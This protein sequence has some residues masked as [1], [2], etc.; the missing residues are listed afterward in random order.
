MNRDSEIQPK[1]TFHNATTSLPSLL[2]TGYKQLLKKSFIP[3]SLRRISLNPILDIDQQPSNLTQLFRLSKPP[4]V[5]S[6]QP[7]KQ[8]K[9]LS[10]ARLGSAQLGSG[11]SWVTLWFLS[12]P[13]R[14]CT[15]STWWC[16]SAE[17]GRPSR[18]TCSSTTP[19]ACCSS[20]GRKAR[21]HRSRAAASRPASESWVPTATWWW[22]LTTAA[23][24]EMPCEKRRYLLRERQ[25]RVA[26]AL[27]FSVCERKRR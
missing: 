13:N 1:W 19:A 10:L 5:K 18:A 14:C 9:H 20:R 15:T 6:Q 16:A 22:P 2:I 12:P 11:T 17:A 25:T 4:F 23:R 24:S 8:K 3:S 7:F 26:G 27:L 21:R